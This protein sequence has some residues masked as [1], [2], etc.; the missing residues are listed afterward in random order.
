MG[1]HSVHDNEATS[2]DAPNHQPDR[3]AKQQQRHP[4]SDEPSQHAER[5]DDEAC[6]LRSCVRF[7]KLAFRGG[8]GGLGRRTEL[9]GL[10]WLDQLDWLDSLNWLD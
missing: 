7:G 5:S 3:R 2:K 10:N 8:M 9:D 6:V 1:T 4:G